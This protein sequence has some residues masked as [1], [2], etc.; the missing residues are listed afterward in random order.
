MYENP[1]ILQNLRS[2]EA[3]LQKITE[4]HDE[5]LDSH[6]SLLRQFKGIARKLKVIDPSFSPNT[7]SQEI[8]IDEVFAKCFLYLDKFQKSQ[9]QKMLGQTQEFDK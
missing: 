6:F 3:Q 7:E 8:M 9:A 5:L 1:E 2:K 4:K